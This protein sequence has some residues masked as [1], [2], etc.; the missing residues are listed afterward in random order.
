LG[1]ALLRDYS[2]RTRRSIRSIL[3][4]V[5][6][7]GCGDVMGHMPGSD[8]IKHGAVS[9]GKGRPETTQDSRCPCAAEDACDCAAKD[10]PD[11][12]RDPLF[13]AC[14]C[15]CRWLLARGGAAKERNRAA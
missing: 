6:K 11:P 12:A 8:H 1:R 2:C 7:Q 4:H 15:H 9:A 10:R 3:A 13:R 14:H 5:V